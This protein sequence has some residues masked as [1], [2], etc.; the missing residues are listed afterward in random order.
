MID[1]LINIFENSEFAQGG[2]MVVV[3]GSALGIIY[4]FGMTALNWLRRTIARTSTVEITVSES[5]GNSFNYILYWL[6]NQKYTDGFCSRFLAQTFQ[7]KVI[8][9]PSYGRHLF[10]YKG[11]PAWLIYKVEEERNNR[12]EN[13]Q[14]IFVRFFKK[15]KLIQ[16]IIDEGKTLYHSEKYD[17]TKIYIQQ[18]DYWENLLVKAKI[19]SP[20]L[21]N[22][23]DY[24]DLVIDIANFLEQEADYLHK[25]LNYKRGYLFYGPPGNG[26]TTAIV[27][28]SQEM[29][30]HLCI[31]N[32]ADES[33]SE[34]SLLMAMGQLPKNSIVCFEDIDAINS[35]KTTTTPPRDAIDLPPSLTGRDNPKETSAIS[36]S[37]ILN[38]LD[39]VFTP[40]G[41]IFFMTTNFKDSLD[42]ALIRPGRIDRTYE[43]TDTNEYQLSILAKRFDKN[44]EDFQHL[45]GRPVAET[46][47]NLNS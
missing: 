22:E 30:K 12:Y 14:I 23:D 6:K 43:F 44:P 13:I 2:L 41:L 3:G 34:K 19:A 7:D 35:R 32:L 21:S 46:T 37:T 47:L 9:S 39:G 10:I 8:L 17:G 38:V 33:I 4:R 28:L 45:I 18:H 42:T 36:L 27:A 11:K 29:K 1:Y 26:K 25:G 15:K 31:V 40:N 5:H 20:V 16:D 24:N